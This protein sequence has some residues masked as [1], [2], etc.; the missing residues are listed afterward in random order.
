MDLDGDRE[1]GARVKEEP[2]ASVVPESSRK[3][4][5]TESVASSS[6]ASS[7]RLYDSEF[8]RVGSS[9]SF[10]FFLLEVRGY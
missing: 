6:H 5:R 3:R 7:S 2:R 10:C 4:K 8:T 1:D 9:V